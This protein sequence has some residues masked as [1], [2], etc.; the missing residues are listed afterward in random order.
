MAS[1]AAR[2]AR[3]VAIAGP[4]TTISVS[5]PKIVLNARMAKS[6]K[7]VV[8]IP[9]RANAAKV[10]APVAQIEARQATNRI[11]IPGAASMTNRME[12]ISSTSDRALTDM[13][14]G[15]RERLVSRGGVCGMK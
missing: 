12:A 2:K 11:V 9:A 13:V 8:L 14:S 5:S 15:E 7:G 6:Q 4:L 10:A 1:P 3:G